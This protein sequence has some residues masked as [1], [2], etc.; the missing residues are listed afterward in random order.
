MDE[1]KAATALST[2]R[3]KDPL[4]LGPKS[5]REN[6][7]FPGYPHTKKREKARRQR[8]QDKID[9]KRST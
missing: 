1:L 2:F 9:A 7:Y 3:V 5:N 4:G 8:Q 6:K